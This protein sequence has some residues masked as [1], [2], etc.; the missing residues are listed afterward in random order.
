MKHDDDIY[1]IISRFIIFFFFSSPLWFR[2]ECQSFV[3]SNDG[4]QWRAEYVCRYCCSYVAAG[5]SP[6]TLEHHEETVI[7]FLDS[8]GL[9]LSMGLKEGA[10]P[11]LQWQRTR[12]HEVSVLEHHGN[13]LAAAAHHRSSR[14]LL[15][16]S[17]EEQKKKNHTWVI[18]IKSSSLS[19]FNDP[20]NT[21]TL[22]SLSHY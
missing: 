14:F 12:K 18:S 19:P 2:K 6:Q 5:T 20:L 22:V 8:R 10:T 16:F 4:P 9:A 21:Q 1:Y 15:A 7:Q 13:A 17:P 11:W 3:V